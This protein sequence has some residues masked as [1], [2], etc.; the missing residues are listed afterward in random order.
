MKRNGSGWG[1]TAMGLLLFGAG[2]YAMWTGYDIIQ[3]ERGWSL[4]I[5]GAVALTGGVLTIAVG[6]VIAL[7]ARLAYPAPDAE[8][9]RPTISAATFAPAAPRFSNGKRAEAPKQENLDA[10]ATEVDRYNNGDEVYVMFSDGT[11]E[12]SGPAG[13]RRY[14]SIAALRAEAEA[15][16]G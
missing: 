1:V 8:V 6:C 15:L 3:L 14:P 11:V 16:K 4:F 2:A 12:V 10:P 7:L 9:A 5:A 13:F